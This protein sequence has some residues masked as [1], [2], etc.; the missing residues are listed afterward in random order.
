MNQGTTTISPAHSMSNAT[1]TV[2]LLQG[3]NSNRFFLHFGSAPNS[4]NEVEN[5]SLLTFF[6]DNQLFVYFSG[7]QT[8]SQVSLYDITGRIIAT[9]QCDN[10]GC[11][12]N[13][14]HLGRGVY[15]VKANVEKGTVT[16]K[17][18]IY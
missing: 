4:I 1:T 2:T 18:N 11:T 15:I 7:T 10:T 17:V 8:I 14:L 13:T 9:Q 12:F 16:R 5:S 3:D 6:R